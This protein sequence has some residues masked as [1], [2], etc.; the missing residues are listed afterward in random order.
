MENFENWACSLRFPVLDPAP[1]TSPRHLT[2]SHCRRRRGHN[3]RLDWRFGLPDRLESSNFEVPIPSTCH[4]VPRPRHWAAL[5]AVRP[6]TISLAMTPPAVAW[7]S[8]RDGQLPL[9]LQT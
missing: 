3:S 1:P 6:V 7:L 2:L 5:K 9:K 4:Q 8:V